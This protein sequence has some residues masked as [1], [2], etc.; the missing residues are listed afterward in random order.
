MIYLRGRTMISQTKPLQCLVSVLPTS[1]KLELG[2]FFFPQIKLT[3]K[4]RMQCKFSVCSA[5]FSIK[6][7]GL[8][9]RPKKGP[10]PSPDLLDEKDL[11][12]P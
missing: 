1:R 11:W 6:Y 10:G 8:L 9:H 7:Y 12:Q 3:F 2:E 4:V 5:S